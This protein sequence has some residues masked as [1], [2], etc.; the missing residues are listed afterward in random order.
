MNQFC[1]TCSAPLFSWEDS[2]CVR[3]FADGKAIPR[4]NLLGE[5]CGKRAGLQRAPNRLNRSLMIFSPVAVDDTAGGTVVLAGSNSAKFRSIVIQNPTGN[6]D[7]ALAF[8]DGDEALTFANGLL[9]KA[10][11][12]RVIDCH[13]GAFTNDVL[14]ICDTGGAA[15]LRVHGIE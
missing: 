6:N 9:L 3:C 7:V 8:D 2:T 12:E 14:A 4:P 5:R 10:G 13:K 11:M 1:H 15:T